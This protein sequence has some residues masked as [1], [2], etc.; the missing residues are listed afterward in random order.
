M[1]Y[2]IPQSNAPLH[3]FAAFFSIKKNYVEPLYL[4]CHSHFFPIYPTLSYF[5]YYRS[6]RPKAHNEVGMDQ[7]NSEA[8][9]EMAYSSSK[10]SLILN[11][12]T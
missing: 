2:V 4:T 12:L 3:I 8:S 9:Q 1:E 7:L 11:F 5:F 6:S 10:R